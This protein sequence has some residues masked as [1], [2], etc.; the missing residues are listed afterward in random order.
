M[1]SFHWNT[2]GNDD[3][4]SDRLFMYAVVNYDTINEYE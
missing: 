4:Q 1:K 3:T 2:I